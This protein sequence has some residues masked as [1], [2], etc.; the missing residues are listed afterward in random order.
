MIYLIYKTIFK[1]T[2]FATN[3]L[4]KAI[5]RGADIVALLPVKLPLKLPTELPMKPPTKLLA[6]LPV[7]LPLASASETAF[8]LC[9]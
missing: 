6:Q 8:D 7:K 1:F 3:L 2:K 9:Q 4:T 5:L